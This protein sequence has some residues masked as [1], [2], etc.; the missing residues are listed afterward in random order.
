M[1]N[2]LIISGAAHILLLLALILGPFSFMP[3]PS[4]LPAVTEVTL[5][6]ASQLDAATSGTPAPPVTEITPTSAPS[7]EANDTATPTLDAVPNETVKD[8]TAA[9]SAQDSNPDLSA[10]GRLAQPSVAIVAPQPFAP[11]TAPQISPTIG[12]GGSGNSPTAS[13]VAPSVPRAAP[14]I[15]SFS[16]P[17]VPDA[18]RSSDRTQTA[19]TPDQNAAN[20]VDPQTATARPESVSQ[21]QPDAQPDAAPSAAPVRRPANAAANAAAILQKIQADEAAQIQALLEAATADAQAS[22][23]SPPS[24]QPATATSQLSSNLSG[25][26]KRAIGSVIGENWNKSIVLGKTN[27]ENLVIRVAVSV[28]ADGTIIGAVEPVEPANPSGD[29]Q[30]AF[31]AARRAVLRA[32]VIPLPAGQYP[33]GVRLILRFDPVAG[34]GLN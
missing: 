23:A 20:P 7:A 6:S 29:F 12:N 17:P 25:A 4:L 31:D 1:K 26:Q 34:I 14:R 15:D 24:S 22:Q 2:G 8:V 27:F 9:P 28:A 30:V 19:T 21:V 3:D 11:D 13:L 18:A 32:G 16:T 33:E 5:V 10:L